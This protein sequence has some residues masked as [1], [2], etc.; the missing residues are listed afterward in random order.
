MVDFAEQKNA[1]LRCFSKQGLHNHDQA[2][3]DEGGGPWQWY[4]G[5]RP[6]FKAPE[7]IVNFSL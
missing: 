2:K 7:L 6:W 4:C 3:A 1:Q 5:P